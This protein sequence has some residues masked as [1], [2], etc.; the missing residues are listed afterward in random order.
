M[1]TCSLLYCIRVELA[2]LLQAQAKAEQCL[3]SKYCRGIQPLAVNPCTEDVTSQ[4]LSIATMFAT[5]P[6]L[7][8]GGWLQRNQA[9][10]KGTGT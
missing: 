7:P 3:F 1:L 9:A 5:W 10:C 6:Y 8:K 2:G 4:S